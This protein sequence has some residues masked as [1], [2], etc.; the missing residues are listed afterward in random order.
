V[1]VTVAAG[2]KVAMGGRKNYFYFYIMTRH[3]VLHKNHKTTGHTKY[4]PSTHKNYG[5][6]TA[7]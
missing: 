5:K 6:N 7:T 1:C 3:V 2:V 4:K